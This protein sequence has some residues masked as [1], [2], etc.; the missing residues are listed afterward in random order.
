MKQFV[1]TDKFFLKEQVAAP[2][3]DA[4]FIVL[5]PDCKLTAAYLDGVCGYE[6][7]KE[8]ER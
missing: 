2:G 4:D 8:G 1:Y 7:E 5:T 6:A 3:Y